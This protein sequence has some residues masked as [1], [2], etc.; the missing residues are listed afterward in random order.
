M[1]ILIQAVRL[2]RALRKLPGIEV[3][4]SIGGGGQMDIFRDGT[5]VFSYQESRVMPT[6]Q[7]LVDMVRG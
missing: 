6:V 7:Q 2:K 1:D 4:T 5:R 3:H